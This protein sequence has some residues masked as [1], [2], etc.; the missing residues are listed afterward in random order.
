VRNTSEFFQAIVIHPVL[1]NLTNKSIDVNWIA[2]VL[3]CGAWR[4]PTVR[5]NM[6]PSLVREDDKTTRRHIPAASHSQQHLCDNLRSRVRPS[7]SHFTFSTVGMLESWRRN[8]GFCGRKEKF[9][10]HEE[11]LRDSVACSQ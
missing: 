10:P 1:I 5:R 7:V 4:F 2:S 9:R 6:T 3:R 11:S 8:C